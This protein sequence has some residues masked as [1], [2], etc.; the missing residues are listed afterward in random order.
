MLSCLQLSSVEGQRGDA[1]GVGVVLEL[2]STAPARPGVGGGVGHGPHK[3]LKP[4]RA[5]QG[6]WALKPFCVPISWLKERGFI[7]PE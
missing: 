5:L 6:S 1:P 4:S 3:A 7:Q 2:W